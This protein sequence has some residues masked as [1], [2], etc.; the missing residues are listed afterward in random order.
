MTDCWPSS[1]RAGNSWE[2]SAIAALG[3][4]GTI[5]PSSSRSLLAD[6]ILSLTGLGRPGDHPVLRNGSA[7]EKEQR[8]NPSSLAI[9]GRT[10]QRLASNRPP[11][12]DAPLVCHR[13]RATA[14]PNHHRRHTQNKT[15]MMRQQLIARV[16]PMR[17]DHCAHLSVARLVR[18]CQY[19]RRRCQDSKMRYARRTPRCV[20]WRWSRSRHLLR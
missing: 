18:A 20:R 2:L 8:W 14:E 6:G 16:R 11:A 7:A 15:Y 19:S 12:H 13:Y 3:R 17:A 10:I 1:L 5:G 9:P 4:L